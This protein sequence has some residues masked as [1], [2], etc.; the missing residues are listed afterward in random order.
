M[1]RRLIVDGQIF[2]T[3]AWHRGMGKYSL[4][5]LKA[6]AARDEYSSIELVVSSEVKSDVNF[7]KTFKKELPAVTITELDLAPNEIGNPEIAPRNRKVIDRFIEEQ[8][9]TDGLD[10]LILSIMQG[11]IYPVFPSAP[12]V[13]KLVIV[14]DLIPLLFFEAYLG[15]PITRVE[16]LSKI[17]ELLKA[18][19]YFTISKT[20]ANDLALNLG[21]D[22]SRVTNIDGGPARHADKPQKLVAPKNFILMPTGNDLRKNNER[23]IRGFEQFNSCH[24]NQYKLLIT[25]YFKK[26]Q[27]EELS[28]LSDNVVFTG[29]ISGGELSYLY[30]HCTALLFPAEYEGLGMPIIEALEFGKPVACSNIAAFREMSKTAFT[31]FDPYSIGEIDAALEKV[32]SNQNVDS[33]E[34][35]RILSKYSWAKTAEKFMARTR[36]LKPTSPLAKLKLAIFA[37]NPA[38]TSRA[39]QFAQTAH[40]ELSRLFDCDYF[41]GPL[42]GAEERVNYLPYIAGGKPLGVGLG[43]DPSSY[44]HTIYQIDNS[45][46][47]A[48]VLFAALANPGIVI[49]HDDNL[50]KCWRAMVDK[51]LTDQSR[52]DLER[53]IDAKLILSRA[54]PHFL[55]SL[56]SGQKAVVVFGESARHNVAGAAKKVNPKLKIVKLALPVPRPVYPDVLE[57]REMNKASMDFKTF[58]EELKELLTHLSSVAKERSSR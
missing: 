16:Y 22:P 30:Q 51:K 40:A 39:G 57:G 42:V 23:A 7:L 38:G 6:S 9:K 29:N 44:V 20:V 17:Q 31:Y 54:R 35:E 5:F 45:T 56:L 11:E 28:K 48:E 10:F 41:L 26:Y 33:K 47:S 3:P 19:H 32:T 34:Y 15:N 43:F 25:S 8:A 46:N 58:S 50:G 27:I 18:D 1:K 52:F 12:V 36:E 55:A 2:Q 24:N 14:Y 53:A 49:L 4:D 21:V 13:H 37:P